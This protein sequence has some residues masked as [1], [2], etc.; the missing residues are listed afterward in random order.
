LVLVH[1]EDC[2]SVFR[3]GGE[4]PHDYLNCCRKALDCVRAQGSLN[5]D[6]RHKWYARTASIYFAEITRMLVLPPNQ[7]GDDPRQRCTGHLIA[8]LGGAAGGT[9]S[10]RIK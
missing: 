1:G 5:E 6:P 9:L 7:N 4:L 3:S 2:I 8:N 10:G